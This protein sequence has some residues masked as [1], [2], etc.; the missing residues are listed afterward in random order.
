MIFTP[1]VHTCMQLMQKKLS[2]CIYMYAANLIKAQNLISLFVMCK[3]ILLFHIFVLN[4][5]FLV[6]LKFIIYRLYW[7]FPKHYFYLT[8]IFQL[9][10]LYYIWIFLF[11]KLH[12]SS[13]C[14]ERERERKYWA[15]F[16]VMAQNDHLIWSI[17][18]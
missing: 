3:C 16:K 5:T 13:D 10:R 1:T 8:D 18:I 2:R 11:A 6:I 14:T 4:F 15:I 9:L 12:V 17:K 7:I